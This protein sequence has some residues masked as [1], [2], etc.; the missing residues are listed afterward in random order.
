MGGMLDGSAGLLGGDREGEGVG[1]LRGPLA[2][3]ADA[4]FCAA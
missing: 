3:T 4:S 2:L 1:C